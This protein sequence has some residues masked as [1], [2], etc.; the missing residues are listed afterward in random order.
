MELYKERLCDFLIS[1]EENLHHS[2]EMYELFKSGDLK[3]FIVKKYLMDFLE[4][5]QESIDKS[6]EGWKSDFKG[7]V[8]YVDFFIF[9]EEWGNLC[10]G[11]DVV[12]NEIGICHRNVEFEQTWRIKINE[13][14]QTTDKKDKMDIENKHWVWYEKFQFDITDYNV[15]FKILPI[16]SDM[17]VSEFSNQLKKYSSIYEYQVKK[18][19]SL[20]KSY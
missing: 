18:I 15:L 19:L 13:Y 5:I 10:I 3:S 7:D 20:K 2:L 12:D 4:K 9:K 6:I 8:N 14:L 17:S 11:W 1:S 16:K